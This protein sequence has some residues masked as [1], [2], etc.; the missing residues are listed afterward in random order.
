[1][2]LFLLG[3]TAAQAQPSRALTDAEWQKIYDKGLLPVEDQPGLPR[4]LLIGDSISVYYTLA[5]HRL[6]RTEANVHRIPVNGGN[7]EFGLQNIDAWLGDGRWDVI[8]FNWGLHDLR[9]K[10][11][12]KLA[13]PLDRYKSNLRQLVDRLKRTGAALI[14]ATTTPVPAHIKEGP[15]RH[16]VDVI[17]YNQA[18][19]EIM[20][21]QHIPIDDLYAF[22]LPRLNQLQVPEDVHFQEIGSEELAR[23]VAA[24]IRSTLA[25]KRSQ[26][27]GAK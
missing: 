13:V 7:T 14:W 27:H 8:H 11:D 18:A 17:A 20:E 16:N 4:V 2:G 19:L 24:A 3:L 12:G 1:M 25:A 26:P 9:V 5:A 22:A 6:L 21:Q 23:Q 15:E 10:E